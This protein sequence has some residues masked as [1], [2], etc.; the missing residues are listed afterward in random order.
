MRSFAQTLLL[1]VTEHVGSRVFDSL[2]HRLK[3]PTGSWTCRWL[4]SKSRMRRIM[5]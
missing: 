1:R 5:T 2:R 4:P 3:S